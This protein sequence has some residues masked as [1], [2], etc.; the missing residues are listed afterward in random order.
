MTD[1]IVLDKLTGSFTDQRK[2]KAQK[3][4][5]KE[6]KADKAGL[7]AILGVDRS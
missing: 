6:P 3:S 4:K 7:T 2:E 1:R 5:P